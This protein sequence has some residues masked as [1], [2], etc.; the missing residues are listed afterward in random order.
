[1]VQLKKNTGFRLLLYFFILTVSIS[2]SGSHCLYKNLFTIKELDPVKTVIN[3]DSEP[4]TKEIIQLNQ[5]LKSHLL[6]GDFEKSRIVVD[7]IIQKISD[8]YIDSRT[9]SD[10]YYYIGVYFSF[11]RNLDKS[12]A[13]FKLSVSL[14]E[15]NQE[16][17]KSYARAMFN[18]GTLCRRMGDLKRFED[19]SLISLDIEKKILGESSPELLSTYSSL[20][21]AYIE[22]QEYEKARSYADIALTIADSNIETI[23]SLDAANLY[24]NLGVL[25]MHLVDYSKAKIFLEKSE[26]IYLKN[27]INLDDNYITLINSMAITYGA[28]GLSDKSSQYYE[29]GISLA[30]NNNSY[31]AY[32]TINSYSIFLGNAGKEQKG[33]LLLNDALHRAKTRFGENSRS[34]FEVLNKYAD[35]LREYNI[36]NRKSID[37]Y[38][39]CMAYLDKN[40]EDLIL[41]DLVYYGY[42]LSLAKAGEPVKAIE[43]IQSLLF[44]DY[45][46][47]NQRG[48]YNNPGINSI[49][50]DRRSLKILKTKYNILRD[51]YQKTSDLET[52]EAASNTSE[53][54][55]SLLEKVRININEEESRL[56]LGDRY[57]DSY[58]NAIQNFNFL[59]NKTIDHKYLEK[60][61]EYSEKSKVAGLLTSTRELKAVQFHIPS[62]IAGF[63]MKLQSEISLS[64]ARIYEESLRVD[65]DTLLISKW[66]G[67]LLKTTRMR[68]SLI[69][70]FEKKY[71]DYYAIKYNTKIATLKQIH[72]II[73]RNGNYINYVASDTILYIFIAN[74]KFDKL[75]TLPV[76]SSF[77]NNI[78]KFR[79]LLS[80]FSP[81]EN[82]RIAFQSYQS[83]GHELY[84]S[85]VY[86]V[87]PYLIST[88]LLISPDNILSYLPFETIP[89][90]QDSGKRIQYNE[91]AYLMNDFDISYTYSAT[92]LGESAGRTLSTG[93]K[94]IVFA[95]V[96]NEPIDIQSILMNRQARM[97]LLPDLPFARQEAKFV[98][99]ITNGKLLINNEARESTFKSESGKYDIIHL[100]MHTILNDKDPMYS[101]MIFSNEND[102]IDDR[103]LKTYE[104]FGIPLKA[105]MVLLSSCNTGMG[106]LYSG[107][108]VLSLARGFMYSGS[109]SVVMSMWEIEDKSGTEIVKLFYKNLKKGNSKSGSL[110]KARIAYL[111]SADQLRSHPYYWS[112]LVVY[113]DN[114]PL[115]YSRY[116]IILIVTLAFIFSVLMI[117]YFRKRKY[118]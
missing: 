69:S 51:I 88:K 29:K 39:K 62:D 48:T 83:I 108:G 38:V 4:G 116:L 13:Y 22:L 53:L 49:K 93:N 95:P 54:I 1:L 90:K 103:Y 34:Y 19:Y 27:N 110:R 58:L 74:R 114:A 102:T 15:K 12:M 8:N 66:N 23:H 67:N 109:Q 80:E 97:D 77:Y 28:L 18:L 78:R 44:S 94:A 2:A 73:G 81:S 89:T 112:A 32:N 76:D 9:L 117:F 52:L 50:P 65:P 111:K 63:E 43:T 37:C 91:I 7:L 71:P 57:R 87:I 35:Y 21:T 107:E 115:Y 99:E 101:T 36:D 98:S 11:T 68:D 75:I 72:R 84:K 46:N 42:S 64:N 85:L 92:F 100:A 82:A 20:I 41:K 6:K 26:S 86:P 106:P 10:T 60:A 25:N 45:D 113:G 59:Y 118:S 14:K 24:N 61:F 5:I 17:D 31:L 33:E 55:V 104:V 3:N 79:N 96:Y 16:F 105:R 56:L 70:V 47:R 40:Q 30:L